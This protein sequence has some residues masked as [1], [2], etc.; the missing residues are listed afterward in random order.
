MNPI[1]IEQID[2]FKNYVGR[3]IWLEYNDFWHTF[4]K[5]DCWDFVGS[6]YMGGATVPDTARY[7]VELLMTKNGNN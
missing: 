6:Y 2:S 1:M 5:S 3:Y 4:D 7:V